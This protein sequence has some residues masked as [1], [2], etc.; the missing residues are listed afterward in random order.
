MNELIVAHDIFKAYDTQQ[1]LHNVNLTLQEGEIFGI[2]GPSG[3]GKSTLL[4]ILDLIEPPTKGDLHVFGVD[5]VK[6]QDRWLEL[7]RRMGMLFQKP[8]VFNTSVYQNVAMGLQYRRADRGEIDRK[9]KAALESVGLSRYIK[10]KARN[11]S[12]GEQQRVALSRVLVTEPEILFL[13]EPTANLDP[14]SVTTIEKIVKRLNR[15]EGTTVVMNTHDRIG[16]MIDGSV[17]QVNTP[18]DI[19]QRPRSA[20]IGKFVGIENIFQGHIRSHGSN[21]TEVEVEQHTIRSTTIPSSDTP[22]VDV[23][24]RGEDIDIQHQKPAE[25]PDLNVFP[26][27]ISS[28]ESIPPYVRV[29]VSCGGLLLKVLFTTRS[30]AERNLDTDMEVWVAF[31]AGVVHLMG[32]GDTV[33]G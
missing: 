14:T 33:A 3:S 22:E 11:L 9:V 24:I 13:D 26:C 18:K 32:R 21:C 23:F 10:S 28:I 15:E 19:F 7:R 4:R 6:E 17:V 1:V 2:I 27:T 8:I 29:E 16:V 20:A 31:H 12:G 5:V 30:A 25:K